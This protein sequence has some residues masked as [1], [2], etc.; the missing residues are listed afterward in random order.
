LKGEITVEKTNKE[1]KQP[2]KRSLYDHLCSLY[3]RLTPLA[4]RKPKEPL[5][6]LTSAVSKSRWSPTKAC[7]LS[8][9]FIRK[10][11]RKKKKARRLGRHNRR[12]NQIF[13]R[14]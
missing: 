2:V 10:I 7:Q 6:R 8:E 3:P 4:L 14:R 9:A 13:A 1:G 12:I 11:S 5:E